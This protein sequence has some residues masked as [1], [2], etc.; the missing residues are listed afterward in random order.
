MASER[1]QRQ[2]DRLLDEAEQASAERHWNVVR[3]RAQHVLEFDSTNA[4]GLL[5]VETLGAEA[6]WA[7]S[8]YNDV[9]D[10]LEGVLESFKL[11]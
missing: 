8:Q 3:E 2:I 9:Q 6:I 5:I 1:I 11:L 4:D 10:I 7:F